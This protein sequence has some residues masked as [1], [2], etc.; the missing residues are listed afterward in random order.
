MRL[1]VDTSKNKLTRRDLMLRPMPEER[2]VRQG[3]GG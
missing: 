3:C 1:Q 2:R